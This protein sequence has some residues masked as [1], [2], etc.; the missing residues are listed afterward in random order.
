MSNVDHEFPGIIRLASAVMGVRLRP[1]MYVGPLDRPEA[2]LTLLAE[3]L[4]LSMDGALTGATHEIRITLQ[5]DGTVSVWDD[6]PGPNVSASRG[7]F[8]AIEKLLTEIYACRR[9]KQSAEG[10]SLCGVGIVIT[11]ALSE[12]LTFETV[13]AGWLWRQKFVHGESAGPIARIEP[14]DAIWHRLTFLPD[15]QFFPETRLTADPIRRWFMEESFDLPATT[16]TLVDQLSGN[17]F[18]LNR[19]IVS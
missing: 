14:Q 17:T 15:R 13:Q 1:A 18:D 9:A 12:W 6:G 7:D 11:N 5:G 8:G 16:V 4:C 19:A 3:S 10:K 2:I